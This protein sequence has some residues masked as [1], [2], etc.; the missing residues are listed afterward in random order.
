MFSGEM[1][2]LRSSPEG[3]FLQH[4]AVRGWLYSC[5]AFSC[6]YRNSVGTYVIAFLEVT[7]FLESF[8]ICGATYVHICS[9]LHV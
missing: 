2:L 5:Y 9:H 3:K 6:Q 8:G 7:K 1:F 4:M